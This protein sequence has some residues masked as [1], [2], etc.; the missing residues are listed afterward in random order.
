MSAGK[1][2]NLRDYLTL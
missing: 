1:P 2:L